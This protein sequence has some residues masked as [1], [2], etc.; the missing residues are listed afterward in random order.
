MKAIAKYDLE[1]PDN[2]HEKWIM[3][4]TYDASVD[5]CGCLHLYSESGFATHYTK[6][7]FENMKSV[8]DFIK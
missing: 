4:N 5:E 1:L 8:F 7:A 2:R 6:D 3:G